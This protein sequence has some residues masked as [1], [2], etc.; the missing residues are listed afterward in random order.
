MLTDT[1]SESEF[2]IELTESSTDSE[3]GD[4]SSDRRSKKARDALSR[5]IDCQMKKLNVGKQIDEF[6][7]TL[8][9]RMDAMIA[10][11]EVIDK[12]FDEM[13]KVVDNLREDLYRPFRPEIK[14]LDP[15]DLD[16]PSK[17]IPLT[18]LELRGGLGQFAIK[19]SAPPTSLQRFPAPTQLSFSGQPQQLMMRPQLPRVAQPIPPE[20]V[21]GIPFFLISLHEVLSACYVVL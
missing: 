8:S 9:N 15:V 18:E 11:A 7:G 2:E 1:S 12:K 17:P 10:D 13:E 5:L 19:R 6:V 16:K 14:F 20:I 3:G 21:V 4:G